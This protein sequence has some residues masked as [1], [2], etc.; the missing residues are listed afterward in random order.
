MSKA[1]AGVTVIQRVKKVMKH[2]RTMIS[3][4]LSPHASV[5]NH[6]LSCQ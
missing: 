3:K 2:A 6:E 1:C 4:M 5:R